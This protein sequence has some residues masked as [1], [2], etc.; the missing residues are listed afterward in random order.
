MQHTEGVERPTP[1]QPPSE[2]P[3]Q[4]RGRSRQAK[5][6][7]DARSAEDEQGSAVDAPRGSRMSLRERSW[8]FTVETLSWLVAIGAL[9][10]VVVYV[11]FDAIQTRRAKTRR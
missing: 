3:A 11:A 10:F 6:T 1:E 5:G 9:V 8:E 2:L 7:L 4:P